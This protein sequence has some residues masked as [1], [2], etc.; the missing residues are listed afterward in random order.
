MLS[1]NQILQ[2]I[3]RYSKVFNTNLHSELDEI[4]TRSHED[5]DDDIDQLQE[6]VVVG[7]TEVNITGNSIV[8]L[9]TTPDKTF[10]IDC[11][12]TSGEVNIHL[13][14]ASVSNRA[15]II[16]IHLVMTQAATLDLTSNGTIKWANAEIL[17]TL[18]VGKEYMLS[19]MDIQGLIRVNYIEY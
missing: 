3:Q 13:N 2:I 4:G 16:V 18:E 14:T 19:V 15:T 11:D 5:I 6:D 7:I 1:K 9:D 12:N 17:E 8:T 10:L